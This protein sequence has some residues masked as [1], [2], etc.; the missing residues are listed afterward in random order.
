[1]RNVEVHFES[2]DRLQLDHV[3]G[4]EEVGGAVMNSRHVQSTRCE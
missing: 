4:G 3:G 1:M 2:G